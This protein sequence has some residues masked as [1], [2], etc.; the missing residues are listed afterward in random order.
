M[1]DA[2]GSLL[3][4]N[5]D[6]GTGIITSYTDADD[7]SG[8]N[9]NV[10]PDRNVQGGATELM[11][12]ISLAVNTTTDLLFV[13]DAS[14]PPRILVYGNA[15]TAALNGNLAPLRR[16]TSTTDITLPLGINFGAND[17]LYVANSNGTIAVFANASNLSGD[18]PAT[19]TITVVLVGILFDVFVDDSDTMYAVDSAGFIYT[20]NNASTLNG[21]GVLPDVELQVQGA[22]FLTAI[23]VDSAGNGYI[24]DPFNGMGAVYGYDNIATRSGLVPPDRTLAG[25]LTQLDVPIRVFLLE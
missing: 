7:L 9:G 25:I 2:G 13:A 20:Y 24:V 10:P 21:P 22:S 8:I 11:Q 1:V 17:D 12:P 16:I 5:L 4:S 6:A 14:L 18:F 23:A 15:S 19:R 3:V